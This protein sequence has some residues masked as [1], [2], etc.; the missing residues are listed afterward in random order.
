VDEDREHV[1]G[2]LVADRLRERGTEPEQQAGPDPEQRGPRGWARVAGGED[3]RCGDAAEH[4]PGDE[5]LA[6][7]RVVAA[8]GRVGH[9]QERGERAGH[10]H[11][12]GDVHAADP[13]PG[14]QRAE[15][16]REHDA[17]DQHGLHDRE[18]ADRQR[19]RLPDEPERVGRDAGQPERPARHAQQQSGSGAARRLRLL[20]AGLLLQD[21]AEREQQRGGEGEEHLHGGEANR[22]RTAPGADATGGVARTQAVS[23]RRGRTRTDARCRTSRSS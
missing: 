6:N 3:E 4:R 17:G 9:E 14:E 11:G 10:D 13:L 2:E 12:G 18:P 20:Q 23:T 5:P 21:G 8:A 15:R 22:S 1:V 16:Q 19:N 7:G